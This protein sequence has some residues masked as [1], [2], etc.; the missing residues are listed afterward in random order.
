MTRWHRLIARAVMILIVVHAWA[1]TASWG[2][3]RHQSM[4]SALRSV[5]GLPGLAA[6]AAGTIV[7]LALKRD[8]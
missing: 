7:P 6:A 1:A 4:A 2:E 3:S 8:V 5:L